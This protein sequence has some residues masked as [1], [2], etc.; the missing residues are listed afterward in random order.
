MQ[1]NVLDDLQR[2]LSGTEWFSVF[3][4]TVFHLLFY[5]CILHILNSTLLPLPSNTH[6]SLFLYLWKKKCI[7]RHTTN[8]CLSVS[9]LCLLTLWPDKILGKVEEVQTS[10]LKFCMVGPTS[11]VSTLLQHSVI[12][13]RQS[14]ILICHGHPYFYKAF[15]LLLHCYWCT[16]DHSFFYGIILQIFSRKGSRWISEPWMN[17]SL[18]VWFKFLVIKQHLSYPT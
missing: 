5:N 1:I 11:T 8:A 17:C 3:I 16:L 13:G 18:T 10:K 4:I 15:S 6:F 7:H 2:T 14:L 9:C 12:Y